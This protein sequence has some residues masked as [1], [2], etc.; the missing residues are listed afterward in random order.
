MCIYRVRL[1]PTNDSIRTLQNKRENGNTNIQS[2]VL[3]GIEL[4]KSDILYVFK[5]K[6]IFIINWHL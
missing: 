2:A 1:E 3:N 4:I 6:N 5:I